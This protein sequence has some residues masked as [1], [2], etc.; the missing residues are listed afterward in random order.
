M[1]LGEGSFGLSGK[2]L[3]PWCLI[4]VACSR[5]EVATAPASREAALAEEG[6]PQSSLGVRGQAQCL[7]SVLHSSRKGWEHGEQVACDLELPGD[8]LQTI[9]HQPLP[10][11]DG[12]DWKEWE[13]L[14][15]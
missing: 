14:K 4:T 13:A 8:L 15:S 12:S 5:K 9:G 3:A 10:T 6:R 1:G 7:G 2:P 11:Q